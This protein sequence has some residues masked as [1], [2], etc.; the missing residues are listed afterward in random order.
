MASS[1]RS[2]ARCGTCVS[3][4]ESSRQFAYVG[5]CGDQESDFFLLEI[6]AEYMGCSHH[7]QKAPQ[8]RGLGRVDVGEE[9]GR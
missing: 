7:V 2:P 8:C 1:E 3:Y 9:V 4:R 5:S 6:R